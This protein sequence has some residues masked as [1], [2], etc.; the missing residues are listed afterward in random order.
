VA[1]I[2]QRLLSASRSSAV[3]ASC[4]GPGHHYTLGPA[5]TGA[6]VAAQPRAGTPTRHQSYHGQV[7]AVLTVLIVSATVLSA[8]LAP[9]GDSGQKR[10]KRTYQAAGGA[11]LA[12]VVDRAYALAVNL[13]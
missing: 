2:L 8:A 3:P 1:A 11:L 13:R 9:L 7:I 5:R 4:A 6:Y 12:A 10:R